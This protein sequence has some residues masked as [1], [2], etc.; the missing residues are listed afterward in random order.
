MCG[1]EPPGQVSHEIAGTGLEGLTRNRPGW[2]CGVAADEQG[3]KPGLPG[4]IMLGS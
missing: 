2:R 1:T 3:T 4:Y